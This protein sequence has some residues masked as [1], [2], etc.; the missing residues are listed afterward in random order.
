[1]SEGWWPRRASQNDRRR[2]DEAQSV[3]FDD[4]KSLVVVDGLKAQLSI[5]GQCLLQVLDD[6][7]RSNREM[8]KKEMFS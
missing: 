3:P 7:P 5:E 6:E 8:G 4:R 1:M 2:G